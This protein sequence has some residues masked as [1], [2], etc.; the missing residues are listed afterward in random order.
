MLLLPHKNRCLK[1][2]CKKPKPDN[3]N[4]RVIKEALVNF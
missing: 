1:S 2:I 4:F 3:Y